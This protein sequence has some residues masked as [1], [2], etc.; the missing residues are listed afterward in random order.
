MALSQVDSLKILEDINKAEAERQKRMLLKSGGLSLFSL[1]I[2]PSSYGKAQE[3]AFLASVHGK[4]A[5]EAL[6][7]ADEMINRFYINPTYEN[8]EDAIGK[9]MLSC[10]NLAVGYILISESIRACKESP[11]GFI[12]SPFMDVDNS[13]N[14]FRTKAENFMAYRA[15]LNYYEKLFIYL[16][17]SI[18]EVINPKVSCN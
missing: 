1:L 2:D 13:I 16:D 11:T 10:D 12:L 4:F 8:Y 5:E 9:L 6:V 7:E 15:Q 18:V 3:F 17:E 14:K